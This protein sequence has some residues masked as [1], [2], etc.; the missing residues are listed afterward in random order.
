[1]PRRT[2]VWQFLAATVL[3]IAGAT[4]APAGAPLEREFGCIVCGD[5]GT[6][7]ALSNLVLF[8]P[9]GAA[10]ALGGVTAP[11]AVALGTLFSAAI[12][13]IQLGLPS[14][15]PSLGDVIFNA[16]GCAAGWALAVTAAGWARPSPTRSRWLA[17]AAGLTGLAVLATTGLLLAPS[18][19]RGVYFAQ[20]TPNLGSM[21]W[22]RGRVTDA[23][24]GGLFL[25]SNRLPHAEAVRAWLLQGR[26][27][28]VR[29]VAGPPPEGLS[30]LFSI[31]DDRQRQILLLGPDH[32]DLVLRYRMRAADLRLDRPQLR[33]AGVLRDL[34]PGDSFR[35]T[36]R[37]TARSSCVRLNAAEYCG[38]G[39]DAIAGWSL[40][41]FP[42]ALSTR[43]YPL[44]GVAWIALLA[45]PFG[46]WSRIGLLTALGG[47][48]LVLG[49]AAVPPL[50]GLLPTPAGGWVGLVAGVGLG[51]G[52][53]RVVGGG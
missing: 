30:S 42:D 49:L 41:F 3:L 8:L 34:A 15:D 11:L 26:P 46:Y 7:D 50:T 53:R 6:A 32:M 5:R 33:L 22:Y 43:L 39:Y 52:L 1:M 48:A 9:F 2:R 44:V 17:A 35:V 45:L 38:L 37:G 36:L 13:A 31:A 10:L 47:L 23:R 40:L 25:P 14:R 20:W 18:F 19:P 12:E 4:L 16:G 27:L 28:E 51:M 21:E 24:I 29:A